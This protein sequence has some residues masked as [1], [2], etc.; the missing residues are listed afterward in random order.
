M[1]NFLRVLAVLS[2]LAV[3]GCWV[4]AGAHRGWSQNS[5]P[6]V[7]IDPVTEIEFTEYEKRFRPGVDFL[8][9]GLIGSVALFGVTFLFSRKKN[10]KYQL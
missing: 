3:I 4:A 2:A 6:T 1:R 5:V 7:H 8:A 9:A 10:R